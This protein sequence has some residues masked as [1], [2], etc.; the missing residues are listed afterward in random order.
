MFD[1]ENKYSSLAH[2]ARLVEEEET[3]HATLLALPAPYF[4]ATNL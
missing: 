3:N 4:G 2:F 1:K